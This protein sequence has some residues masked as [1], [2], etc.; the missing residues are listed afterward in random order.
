MFINLIKNQQSR[1]ST[2]T[3]FMNMKN[4]ISFRIIRVFFRLTF[5]IT[6]FLKKFTK[7]QL[8]TILRVSKEALKLTNVDFINSTLFAIFLFSTLITIT[9]LLLL[10]LI[11]YL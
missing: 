4:L 9:T 8:Y 7:E 10:I 1:R 6:E 3:N 5:G 11:L 2:I